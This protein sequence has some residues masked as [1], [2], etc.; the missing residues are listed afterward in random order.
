MPRQLTAASLIA[1]ITLRRRLRNRSFLVQAVLGPLLL[2]TII[3]LA[4]GAT[5]FDATIGIVDADGSPATAGFARGVTETDL[6]GLRFELVASPAD[7]RS[8][9]AD[10]ELDAAVVVPAG[11]T[12][13]LG[14]DEPR[15]VEVLAH[16]DRPI[17]AEVARSVANDL[18]ARVDAARLGTTAAIAAGGDAP[19]PDALADIDLPVEVV[20]RGSGGEVSLAAFFAPAMGLLVLFFSV[21][22]LAR[23]L[24]G[25]RRTHLLDRVRAAPVRDA[26]LL[27]GKALAVVVIGVVSLGTI[28]VAT[29]VGLGA[30]W[31]DPVGV[32]LVIVGVALAVA[33]LSG[34]VA[35]TARTEQQADMLASLFAFT[36]ALIGGNFVGPGNLPPVLERLSLLTPNGWALQGFAELSVGGGSP[37][38]VV[39]HV[40][41]LVGWAVGAGA[42][43]A[44]LLRRR[45]GSGT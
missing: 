8:R 39:P 27:A 30:R 5:G 24:L 40:V 37:V 35:A 28:W 36:F 11:F 16:T 13:S 19:S 4:F 42:L 38:D 2:A 12:A 21:G 7:A 9:V 44:V 41:V 14:G 22:T 1:G 23:D 6:E 10:G 29:T 15:A 32:A 33:G 3:S 17:A 45:L 43:G 25:E 20:Q 26:S 18:R 31:G 34:L